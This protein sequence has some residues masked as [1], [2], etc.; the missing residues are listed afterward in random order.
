MFRLIS[1]VCMFYD[2]QCVFCVLSNVVCMFY[3]VQCV[4]SNVRCWLSNVECLL[5][6]VARSKRLLYF[7]RKMIAII[8][9]EETSPFRQREWPI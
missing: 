6:N 3:E 9:E 1:N 2:V 4:L 7:C 8:N 5:K